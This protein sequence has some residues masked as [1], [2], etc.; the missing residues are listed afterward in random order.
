MKINHILVP[1]DGSEPSRRAFQ[2]ALDLAKKYNS[3]I[4]AVT[5]ILENY[6]EP[7][8]ETP[9]A[10]RAALH[11]QNI[12]ASKLISMLEFQAKESNVEFKGLVLKT[13]SIVDALLSYAN[14]NAIDIIIMGCRGLGGFKKLLLGSVASGISQ[15]SKCPVL[16][17]K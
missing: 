14:S 6:Y 17:I 11:S 5:C 2:F 13:T 3:P 12:A 8:T 15:Y 10:Q 4:I 9:E 1:Y 16:I 7:Y